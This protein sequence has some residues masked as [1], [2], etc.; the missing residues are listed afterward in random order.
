MADD[1]V[2]L[3]GRSKGATSGC[4]FCKNARS[5][6]LQVGIRFRILSGFHSGR[7][8][9]AV[10]SPAPSPLPPTEFIA[11]MDGDAPDVQT[12]MLPMEIVEPFP[13]SAPPEWAPPISLQAASELDSVVVGFCEAGLE[14][15]QWTVKRPFYYEVIRFIWSRRL[16]IEANEL[17]FVLHAHGVPNRFETEL[18]DFFIKGRELLIHAFGKKPVK[19]KRVKP[20]SVV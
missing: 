7:P 12:R 11:Q 5:V 1:A 10:E 13:F 18:S 2:V 6:P 8:G 15:D 17:W 4:P 9:V 19:K 20:L 14:G 16:P 3:C